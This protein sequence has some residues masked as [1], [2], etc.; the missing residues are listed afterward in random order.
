MKAVYDADCRSGVM[1][2]VSDDWRQAVNEVLART[3]DVDVMRIW[4][5]EDEDSRMDPS[6]FVFTVPDWELEEA[7]VCDG[8]RIAKCWLGVY[9]DESLWD[10]FVRAFPQSALVLGESYICGVGKG[11]YL[12]WDSLFYEGEDTDLLM[13]LEE[14]QRCP[15]RLPSAITRTS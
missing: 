3:R 15:A 8:G 9:S 14:G 6:D 4:I 7:W 12:R 1:D 2:G 5:V 11:V 10:A 13:W